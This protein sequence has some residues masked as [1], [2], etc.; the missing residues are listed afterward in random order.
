MDGPL[1]DEEQFPRA[2]ID[3]R[4]VRQARHRVICK[5]L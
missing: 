3:V 2:D 4:A 1:V 5:W